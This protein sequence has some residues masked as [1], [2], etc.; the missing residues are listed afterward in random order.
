MVL[1]L[2][3]SVQLLLSNQTVERQP[4]AVSQSH[5]FIQRTI[6]SMSDYELIQVQAQQ[7]SFAK[8]VQQVVSYI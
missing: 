3:S 8:V 4:Q 2:F 7:L 5:I 6:L 1:H